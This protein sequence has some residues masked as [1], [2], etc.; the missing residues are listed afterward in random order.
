M[1]GFFNYLQEKRPEVEQFLNNNFKPAHVQKFKT[2]AFFHK[3]KGKHNHVINRKDLQNIFLND[4]YLEGKN[5]YL[6]E[7][8]ISQKKSLQFLDSN[9]NYTFQR[10]SKPCGYKAIPL[11]NLNL[12]QQFLNFIQTTNIK[13]TKSSY[14]QQQSLQ[15]Q[16]LNDQNVMMVNS[17][18]S[19]E[20]GF[21][22]QRNQKNESGYN[23]NSQLH[24][25]M[26]YIQPKNYS[27]NQQKQCNFESIIHN[28]ENIH[29]NFKKKQKLLQRYQFSH[30]KKQFHQHNN[31]L[32][33]TTYNNN[34]Q[35][36]NYKP[37]NKQQINQLNDDQC[38]NQQQQQDNSF[39]KN[40]N[41]N[42]K[43]QKQ[44]NFSHDKNL[45]QYC[46]I[47]NTQVHPDDQ[48]QYF[49]NY[50]DKNQQ[51]N[52]DDTQIYANSFQKQISISNNDKKML[53]NLQN[54]RESQQ[55]L[56]SQKQNEQNS[57]QNYQMSLNDNNFSKAIKNNENLKNYQIN[58]NNQNKSISQ[59]DSGS[60]QINY[61]NNLDYNNTNNLNDDND[62]QQYFQSQSVIDIKPKN[63]F[64]DFV[65][66]EMEKLILRVFLYRFLNKEFFSYFLTESKAKKREQ[67]IYFRNEF[68]QQLK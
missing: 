29:N 50:Q 60:G 18:K 4:E 16:Q 55:I 58:P 2:N 10:E 21:Q 59:E 33:Y 49:S 12:R 40:I 53:D 11:E 67:M 64:V 23:Q 47:R 20:L 37:Q 27:E 6:L 43:N 63:N 51:L 5:S 44:T 41:T 56:Q 52:C 65:V 48:Q 42:Q 68:L 15:K 54:S 13:R 9:K 66:P 3:Y 62:S 36:I 19:T 30:F 39:I 38:F 35:N 1:V 14:L 32:S 61:E 45:Y 17:S 25:K 31:K 8:I 7:K 26:I 34:Q 46:N 22:K 57:S 28:F 24:T